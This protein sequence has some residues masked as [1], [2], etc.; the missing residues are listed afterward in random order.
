MLYADQSPILS[1]VLHWID[2]EFFMKEPSPEFRLL[3][4]SP[5]FVVIIAERCIRTFGEVKLFK[6]VNNFL[7]LCL[8]IFLKSKF[9]VLDWA[10]I[11]CEWSSVEP[12]PANLKDVLKD[13]IPHIRFEN[14]SA[15]EVVTRVKTSELFEE[16]YVFD[17]LCKAVIRE[18]RQ[19]DKS[20]EQPIRSRFT[21]QYNPRA[22]SD[23][24]HFRTLQRQPEMNL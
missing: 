24:Q 23:L 18:D 9:Q 4:A 12:N 8:L 15:S 20:S 14:L 11:R 7:D 6:A 22:F 2:G 5:E 10:K 13:V 19:V 1:A 21:M 16:T 17:L 3:N